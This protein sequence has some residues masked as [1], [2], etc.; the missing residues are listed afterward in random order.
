MITITWKNLKTES[1]R[2]QIF[3]SR[4]KVIQ[5]LQLMKFDKEVNALIL[6]SKNGKNTTKEVI[7]GMSYEGEDEKEIFRRFGLLPKRED[8]PDGN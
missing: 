8:Y 7:V 4:D 3:K 1:K 2:I 6:A 5:T